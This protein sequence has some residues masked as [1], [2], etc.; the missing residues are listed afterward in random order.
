MLRRESERERILKQT[1]FF[2]LFFSLFSAIKINKFIRVVSSES[3][4]SL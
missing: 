4:S 2:I 1:K 3:Y